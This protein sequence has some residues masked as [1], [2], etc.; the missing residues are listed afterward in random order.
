[1]LDSGSANHLS[2]LAKQNPGYKVV[3]ERTIGAIMDR[4]EPAADP[5]PASLS[6]QEQALFGLGYYHQRNEFFRKKSGTEETPN[7]RNR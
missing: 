5:F 4:M 6:A 2:K 3:L 7:D 1:V